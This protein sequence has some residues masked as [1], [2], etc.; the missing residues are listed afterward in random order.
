VNHVAS[1]QSFIMIVWTSVPAPRR[2][3]GEASGESESWYPGGGILMSR[4]TSSLGI[5]RLTGNKRVSDAVVSFPG[6]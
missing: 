4:L 6:L 5:P 2:S 3:N 1:L